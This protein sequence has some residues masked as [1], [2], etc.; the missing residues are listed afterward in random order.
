ML[1]IAANIS[2]MF[3]EMP[4]LERF[5]AARDAGFDGVE[6]QFPYEDSVDD[7]ARA[8]R[9]VEMPV[10]LINAPVLSQY[11][12]GLAGRPEMR[13]CFRAQLPQIVEYAHALEV[14]H[15]HVLAGV[16]QSA[17]EIERCLE[18]YTGSLLLAA[19]AL[20]PYGVGVLVEALNEIDVPDYLVDTLDV[21][22]IVLDRCQRRVSMQFDVYHVT[23]MGLDAAAELRRWLP[24]VR[25]VQFADA[26]GR[27]EP[28]TGRV[29]FD[30][31]LDVLEGAA[32]EGWISAEY[33]PSAGTAQGLGW[34]GQWRSRRAR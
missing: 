16:S 1:K 2:L 11:P 10:V 4:V 14:Q 29:C 32:Y 28:G 30:A 18:M 9:T 19:D 24:L 31:L 5:R 15:V 23:R 26:P 13:E 27:H 34:L 25:H 12:A 6:M 22:Q 7:L 17:D 8:A 33:V 3:R 21:A 20:K